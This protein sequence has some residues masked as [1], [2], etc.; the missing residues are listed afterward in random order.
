MCNTLCRRL[1]TLL[2]SCTTP[3]HFTVEPHLLNGYCAHDT[4]LFSYFKDLYLKFNKMANITY[5]LVIKFLVSVY[6]STTVLIFHYAMIA[7]I[8]NIDMPIFIQCYTP[9]IV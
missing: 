8:S 6:N 5:T 1:A 3:D 2:A 7:R 4:A 9:W